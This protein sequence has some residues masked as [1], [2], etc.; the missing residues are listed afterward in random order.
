MQIPRHVQTGRSESSFVIA[1]VVNA[2]AIDCQEVGRGR[3]TIGREGKKEAPVQDELLY[4]TCR[5]L[6]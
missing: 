6:S 3:V 1:D 2:V 4:S 5:G